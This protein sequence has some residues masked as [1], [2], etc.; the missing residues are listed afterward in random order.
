MLAT[1]NHH[2]G[3]RENPPI[4]LPTQKKRRQKN[5]IWRFRSSPGVNLGSP[6]RRWEKEVPRNHVVQQKKPLEGGAQ[7]FGKKGGVSPN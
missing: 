2:V 6:Y 5:T 3:E 4:N 1:K 7:T